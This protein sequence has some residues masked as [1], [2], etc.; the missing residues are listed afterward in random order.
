MTTRP[1]PPTTRPGTVL[2]FRDRHGVPVEATVTD[3]REDPL[4]PAPPLRSCLLTL[5]YAD[6][7][8]HEARHVGPAAPGPGAGYDALDN[9]ILAGLRLSRLCGAGPYPSEVSRL[10][11]YEAD[12]ELPFV[13][14]APYRGRPVGGTLGRI[15]PSESLP[16]QRSLL[17][18]L[19]WTSAAGIAH[20]ALSPETVHWDTVCAQ[21]TGFTEAA[22]AGTP[23][24]VAGAPPWW[25]P[26]QRPGQAGGVVTGDDDVWAAGRL[27]FCVAT[28]RAPERADLADAPPDLA[29][30][31]QGV[32][33]PPEGRPSVRE[34]LRRLDAA[35]P[36]PRGLS[37]DVALER[38][39][40]DFFALRARKHP[41]TVPA[42][43][44]EPAW[45]APAGPTIP[46]EPSRRG[47][48]WRR[49]R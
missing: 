2:R 24:S 1:E 39:R 43:E 42:A 35:D 6:G 44:P 25:A 3:R 10:I 22:P 17:T 16:F 5:S 14:L 34:L 13:L 31:L 47:R 21:I 11:G 40:A 19:R 36:V 4:Q 26:E 20:R 46:D 49:R 7:G 27:I 48:P 28:G 32:F 45:P 37:P 15:L 9:E 30:L 23:R 29:R 12:G 18:G 33:G 38:G 41:Q 8:R